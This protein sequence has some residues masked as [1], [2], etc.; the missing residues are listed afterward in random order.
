MS[1]KSAPAPIA[2]GQNVIA[3]ID[4]KDTAPLYCSQIVGGV[5]TLQGAKA[6]EVPVTDCRPA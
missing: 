6:H 2:A 5:A 3:K 1:Q 4:G